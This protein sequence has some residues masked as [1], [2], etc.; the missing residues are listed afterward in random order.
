M[1]KPMSLCVAL[2]LLLSAGFVAAENIPASDFHLISYPGASSTSAFG[3]SNKNVV[4]GIYV[5]S[6]GQHGFSVTEAGKFTKIDNPAGTTTLVGINSKG[7]IV[8]YYADSAGITFAFYYSNG[9]FT[10]IPDP[11][12]GHNS[13]AYGI[14]D[15]GVISGD[16]LD[17]STGMEEGW[18]SI[19]T[20]GYNTVLNPQNGEPALA[21]D[22][23]V[24]AITTV[25]WY[26]GSNWEASLYNGTTYTTEN[27]PG[28]INSYI[29]AIDAAGD[30]VYSWS[31]ALG[32]FHGAVLSGSTGNFTTFDAPPCAQTLGD[33]INDHHVIVGSCTESNGTIVGFYVT[34]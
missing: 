13:A 18:F 4:V 19:G 11:P 21:F 32:D 27:V 31:D 10:N 25:Q 15:D 26:S 1:I 29:H 16:Y 34:Y 7:T 5:D 14:N 2:L 28:A 8:G 22:T 30:A 17:P 24:N 9:V 33:G 12:G 6:S 23:N 3:I 20:T